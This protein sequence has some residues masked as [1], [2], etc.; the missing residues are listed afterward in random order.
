MQVSPVS[1]IDQA[2]LATFS[3]IPVKRLDPTML[4][5]WRNKATDAAE[6][7]LIGKGAFGK[8]NLMRYLPT[9]IPVAVKVQEKKNRGIS[10]DEMKNKLVSRSMKEAVMHHVMSDNP[11]FPGLLGVVEIEDNLGVV[12]EFIGD[13]QFVIIHPLC[14]VLLERRP[15][16]SRLEWI[17]IAFD[18]IQGL[19][20]LHDKRLLH[21]DLKKNNILLQ[22]SGER[23]RAYIIDFGHGSTVTMPLKFPT[24]SLEEEREYMEGLLYH[25]LAPE[26]VR[27]QQPTSV[28]S[29]IYSLG[30]VLL[31]IGRVS[32]DRDLRLVAEMCTRVKPYRRPTMSNVELSVM[33][34]KEKVQQ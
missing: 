11:S 33:R 14:D 9:N 24:F 27:D 7:I 34:T 25:H 13:K 2:V 15:G 8:V 21:N 31:D 19:A 4:Q 6:E 29:D 3:K 18:I 1:K 28:Y 16:L 10:E 17:D 30:K 32:G 23:W 26:I 5:L 22:R 20:S 12:L